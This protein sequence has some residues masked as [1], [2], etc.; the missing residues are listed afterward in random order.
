MSGNQSHLRVL[1]FGTTGT[2]DSIRSEGSVAFGKLLSYTSPNGPFV[3]HTNKS[4]VGNEITHGDIGGPVFDN[5]LLVGIHVI[6]P[7]H[8]QALASQEYRAIS[9]V[10][11]WLASPEIRR[12]IMRTAKQWNTALPK[13]R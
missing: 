11:F 6:A 3:F 7:R 9:G 5:N 13:S 8:A 4:N 2:S 12:W 1:G 10:H